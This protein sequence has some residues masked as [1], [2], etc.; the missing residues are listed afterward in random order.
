MR[1]EPKHRVDIQYRSRPFSVFCVA[2]SGAGSCR[3]CTSAAVVA[4]LLIAFWLSAAGAAETNEG[5]IG[6][7]CRA[8]TDCRG[9][10]RC[11][12]QV[13]AVPPAVL[14]SSDK[15]T[16]TVELVA[17]EVSRGRFFVELAS[18]KSEQARGLSYRPS[19]ADGWGMLFI[20]PEPVRHAFTMALMRFPLDIVFIREDGVVVDLIEDAQ[21]KTQALIPSSAYGYVLELNTGAVRAHGIR[22]GD[23]MKLTGVPRRFDRSVKQ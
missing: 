3:V 20:F 6:D 21:P 12:D 18:E 2:I 11:L 23:R 14:G 13:C 15:R 1:I 17:G 16:P 4:S 5:G 19:M 8:D 7:S 22:V 10:W 9:Y